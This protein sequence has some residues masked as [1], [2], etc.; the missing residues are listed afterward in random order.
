MLNSAA[1]MRRMFGKF[2][3]DGSGK[4]D[5]KEL[6][7]ATKL[8]GDHFSDEDIEVLMEILDKDHSDTVDVEEF[9]QHF[10]SKKR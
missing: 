2:D 9:I 3:K 4:L 6:Q 5:R 1:L 7:K 8:L 10:M